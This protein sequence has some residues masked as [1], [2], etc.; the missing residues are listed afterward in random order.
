MKAHLSLA[1][2]VLALVA[3]AAQAEMTFNRIAS[4]A[5][6]DNMAEGED[7][8]RET[9]AE[10]IAATK[11]GRTLVY[12][13]SPMGVVGMIDITDPA[14]PKPLGTVEM[15][16][17]PTSVGVIGATAFVGVNTSES[18]TAPSGKLVVLDLGTRQEEVSCDLG[19]QPDSVAV[20]KD[21]SF[22]AV[23][24]ENERDEDLGDGRVGQMPEGF[25]VLLSVVD[26]IADC[27]SL[28]KVDL[29]GL[30]E[31]APEDPEPEFVDI[32][33]LGEVVVTLQENNHIAVVSARGE[34]L[35]HFS[36]GSVDL[37][38]IDATDERGALIFTESQEGRLRE[39]DAV[40]WID[41]THFATAN[42]GDMD[43]GSR[44]WRGCGPSISEATW[45][46]AT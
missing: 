32:N 42:E 39:P 8:A 12:T 36:A 10:I 2:S 29:T 41:D 16:G 45:R 13:D 11:D 22:V 20:A 31:I 17:E 14:A 19:G 30:A 4:F 6:P 35:S 15:G 9:S 5:T 25:L 1:V 34:V 21:G 28:V 27:E 46:R 3:G 24:I 18:Y 37:D 40:K 38:G 26:G 44:G 43:G 7:R 33:S 23:A